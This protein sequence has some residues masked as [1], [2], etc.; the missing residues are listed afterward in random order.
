MCRSPNVQR[1]SVVPMGV[2]VTRSVER[3]VASTSAGW[4][5]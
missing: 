1:K 3:G 4:S 2:P 5:A